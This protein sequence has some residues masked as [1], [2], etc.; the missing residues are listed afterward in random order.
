VAY[1]PLP[2]LPVVSA[3]LAFVGYNPPAGEPKVDEGEV[4]VKHE[5]FGFIP[6][7]TV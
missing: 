2:L 5:L 6:C 1:L 4:L 7:E 3:P